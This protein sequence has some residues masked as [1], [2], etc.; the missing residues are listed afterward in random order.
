MLKISTGNQVFFFRENQI[1]RFEAK[2]NN[3]IIF[4][5]DGDSSALNQSIDSIAGQLKNY[6]FI[7]VHENHLVNVTHITGIPGQTP[8]LIEVN[9]SQLLPIS[10]EQKEIIIQLILSHFKNSKS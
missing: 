5:S 8:D 6:G 9:N 1:V 4:L 3:T 2:G 7:R 10:K